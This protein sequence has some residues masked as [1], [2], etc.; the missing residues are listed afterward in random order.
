[1]LLPFP[2]VSQPIG[3]GNRSVMYSPQNPFAPIDH[4]NQ[5]VREAVNRRYAKTFGTWALKLSDWHISGSVGE[6]E[7]PLQPSPAL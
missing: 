4:S 1:M 6:S 3:R 5:F 2:R 7:W